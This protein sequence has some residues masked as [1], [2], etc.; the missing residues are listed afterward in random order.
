MV[1]NDYVEAR[2]GGFYIR[3]T[4]V[5]LDYSPKTRLYCSSRKLSVM[6]AM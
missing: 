5:P 1:E 3:K 4:P 2:D 6:P